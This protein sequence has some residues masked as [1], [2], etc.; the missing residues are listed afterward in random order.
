MTSPHFRSGT[1]ST[2]YHDS[3][4]ASPTS[5]LH[6]DTFVA[7]HP[8]TISASPHSC[9]VASATHAS[10]YDSGTSPYTSERCGM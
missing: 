8:L 3:H 6:S 9:A 7:S 2:R 4:V 5:V 1:S 10:F